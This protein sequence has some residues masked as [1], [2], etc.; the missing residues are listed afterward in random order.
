MIAAL[1][2]A[3]FPTFV[4]EVTMALSKGHQAVTEDRWGI[5]VWDEAR[6]ETVV[7]DV[8][9]FP[10]SCIMPPDGVNSV[11]WLEGGMQGAKC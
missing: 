4:G 5:T 3:T 10:A 1:E 2:G 7:K 9:I 11:D 6:G 8:V